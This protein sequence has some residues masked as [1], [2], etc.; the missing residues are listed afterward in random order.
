MT[1]EK[2]PA[3]FFE[4]QTL[5]LEFRLINKTDSEEFYNFI[6]RNKSTFLGPFPITCN[7]I[8]RGLNHT[9]QWINSKALEWKE[10]KSAIYIVQNRTTREIIFMVSVFG[11]D[12]RVPKCEIAWMLDT[13]FES[14]GIAHHSVQLVIQNLLQHSGLQKIICRIE[15]KNQ[16]SIALANRLGFQQEGLHHLDFRDGNG[17]LVD[18]EYFGLWPKNME[19]GAQNGRLP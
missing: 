16:R 7:S 3:K 14:L 10:N 13:Q 19:I 15:P 1:L 17:Q 12:W 11:F 18:V 4:L 2:I 8:L 6:Q 5:Q 9:K